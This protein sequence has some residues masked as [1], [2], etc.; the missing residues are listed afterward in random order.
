MG[1]CNLL[2]DILLAQRMR[3]KSVVWLF[4]EGENYSNKGGIMRRWAFALMLG[5]FLVAQAG[6]AVITVDSVRTTL[7][8]RSPDGYYLADPDENHT[9]TVYFT[10]ADTNT[11]DSSAI[12]LSQKDCSGGTSLVGT[13]GISNLPPGS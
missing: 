5:F 12:S 8:H 13:A 10:V 11:E 1:G 7:P 2:K 9:V 6:A 4:F 3:K